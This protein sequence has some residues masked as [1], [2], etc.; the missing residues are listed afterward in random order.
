[1]VNIELSYLPSDLV[2]GNDSP[3]VF[4]T[5]DRQL[6]NFLT[7]VKN[8]ASRRLC[9]CIRSKVESN[10]N[11]EA[12][13]SPNREEEAMLYK[14]PDAA[15]DYQT[16]PEEDES[17]DDNEHEIDMI[18]G[19]Y[20]RFS[21]VDVV[22]KGQHFSS[23][24]ALKATMEICAM[25]HNFDY[26]LV[27]SDKKVWYVR[28]AD[29]DC[30]WRVRAEGLTVG[31]LTMHKYESVKEGPKPNDIIQLMHND[32]G[33]EIS[34][35]L[36]WEAREYAVN[37]VR[38]IPEEV[39][40]EIP[41]YLHMMKEAN[42][43]SHT[44][45][46]T[47][48]NGRF[49]FLFIS[50]GQS[51]RGF[52]TA[53][54][55]VIVVDGTFL[56]SKYKG[57]LLV[58]TAL[59]GNSNLYPIAFG[60]VDSENDRA[61]EWNTSIAKAPAKVYPHS[62]HGI[63]IHHLLNNVVTYYKGKGVADADVQKWARCQFPG[64][65]YDVRT[66][67][68]AESINSALRS[69]REFPVIPL[70]DS[71]MEMMTRWFFKR[72]TKSSKHTKPLT[73][74]VEK[75]INRRI[76]KSKKFQVFPVSDD[77]FLV[78]GDTFEC[79]VDLVRRTCS[80]GKFDLMKIP[81]RHAIKAAF[82]VGI[83]AH[84]LTDDMYTTAS[85]RS[86]YAESINPISVPED[87]WIAPPHVQQAEVLPPE[88]RRAAGRRKKRRYETVEDKIRSSQGTQR[89]KSRKCSRCGGVGHNRS[90]CDRAI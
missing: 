79:M 60:D 11:E 48:T 55:R 59:D 74:A 40:G 35:P 61:W 8:Q 52:Q 31:T 88:T 62:H 5:T 15:I 65:R 38:G 7:Y 75:K 44:F 12:A 36:A 57:V 58:A 41:K 87:A 17:D 76:E 50:Y 16:K 80:C 13:E 66:T 27:K 6:K 86:I 22:K 32:H 68:P 81:C 26:K 51:I 69:P 63:C 1:M 23:K 29:N 43:G 90:T 67:N 73:I 9:V 49:R 54:R 85:W 71:I 19:K 24:T 89:Y 42:P 39:Y 18:T 77:R 83:R 56:K 4:I 30:T 3:P 25:K 28:C 33:V 47:D 46:E 37:A 21:L 78:Q 84:T 82:S 14:L 45:Y 64:Y 72:R 2:S 10:M 34:Y 53:L 20:V 70:L